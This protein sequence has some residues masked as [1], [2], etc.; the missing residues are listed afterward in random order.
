M[1]DEGLRHAQ[2]AQT[3]QQSAAEMQGEAGAQSPRYK[4]TEKL[5]IFQLA[6]PLG[7]QE[8]RKTWPQNVTYGF[9]L[10]EKTQREKTEMENWSDNCYADLPVH[11]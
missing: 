5:S 9:I 10:P 4:R 7:T 6:A 3:G 8:T 11:P 2:T 1:S